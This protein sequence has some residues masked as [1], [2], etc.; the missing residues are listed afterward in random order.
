MN[1]GSMGKLNGLAFLYYFATTLVAVTVGL[2][3][4]RQ[5]TLF[6]LQIG[7]ALV[8]L[9]HP[10][11]PDQKVQSDPTR[12]IPENVQLHTV[13]YDLIMYGICSKPVIEFPVQK[14][15]SWQHIFCIVSIKKNADANYCG[16]WVIDPNE[17]NGFSRTRNLQMGRM[18]RGWIRWVIEEWRVFNGKNFRI[19][20]LWA[21]NWPN[22][23]IWQSLYWIKRAIRPHSIR[24]DYGS[25]ETVLIWF[26]SGLWFTQSIID[27]FDWERRTINSSIG[28]EIEWDGEGSIK[29]WRCEVFTR[30]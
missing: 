23:W 21:K 4:D 22:W 7:L 2:R 28:R 24:F 29:G 1:A 25:M 18:E 9:I 6:L 11:H 26:H 16:F 10:G 13:I 14:S 3:V 30:Y 27:W 19:R 8:M 12:K 15:F 17:M 5:V 20:W